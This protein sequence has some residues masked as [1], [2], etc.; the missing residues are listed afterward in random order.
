[1]FMQSRLKHASVRVQLQDITKQ[2]LALAPA[3]QGHTAAALTQLASQVC[4]KAVARA[5]EQMSREGVAH[6]IEYSQARDRSGGGH[7]GGVLCQGGGVQY[8][9]DLLTWCA[10]QMRFR[11]SSF[12]AEWGV[13]RGA[14]GARGAS[15]R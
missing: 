3:T 15:R 12:V 8:F 2:M 13:A 1:M 14:R 6:T 5:E 7:V 4:R 10:T 11:S 9:Y